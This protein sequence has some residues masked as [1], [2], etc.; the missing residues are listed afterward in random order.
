MKNI[1]L[2]YEHIKEFLIAEIV[3][4]Y[5]NTFGHN[6]R[7]LND[8][9][10]LVVLSIN[11]FEAHVSSQMQKEINACIMIDDITLYLSSG[12]LKPLILE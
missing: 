6:V 9:S 5:S 8:T 11:S 2:M 1:S 3:S 7:G 10:R 12:K 4:Y